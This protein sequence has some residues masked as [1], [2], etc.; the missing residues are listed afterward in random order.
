MQNLTE[1]S[2]SWHPN[3]ALPAE[4][5]SIRTRVFVLVLAGLGLLCLATLGFRWHVSEPQRFFVYLSL[6]V[7]CSF[8]QVKRP[9]LGTTFSV[10]LPFV[11]ISIVQLSLGEA[12]VVGCCAGLVQS[13]WARS[14]LVDTV[15]TVGLLATV[16]ATA[17]FVDQSLLPQSLQN[18]TVRLF[19]A[20]SALFVANTF[21]AAIAA[22]LSEK[23]RLSRLW[24]ESF[25]WSFPYYVIAAAVAGVLHLAS[26]SASLE[27]ELLAL[28]VI[29]VAYRY[30]RG[31]KAQ[32]EEKQKHAGDLAA[33]HLRAIEGLA[34]AV[35]AKDNLNTRGHLRRVQA[36][37]LE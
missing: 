9:G 33:L 4:S 20:A 26:T 18:S 3:S 13:L 27:L 1:P 15:L 7:L 8:V 37:A 34:L 12:V 36:Y 14:K 31:Q 2:G 5:V 24:K 6:A 22:R 17:D 21:P 29:Y 11:L 19:V 35:E 10:S 28:P 25:F 30:Y 16:I 32:L 23:K